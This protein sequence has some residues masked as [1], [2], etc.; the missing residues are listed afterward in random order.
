[1]LKEE[2]NC[3]V[4]KS[5]ILSKIDFVNH[6]FSTR[7]G[8]VSKNE[9]SS[10]NLGYNRGDLTENV[11]QNFSVLLKSHGFKGGIVSGKQIHGKEIYLAQKKDREKYFQGYD[12]FI[13]KEKGVLL[14][15]FHADCIPVFFVDEKIKAIGLAHSGW[16]GTF[17]NIS[18]EI[19][20]SMEEEFNSKKE[21]IK[22]AIG[23]SICQNCFEVDEDVY[24][25]FNKRYNFLDKYYF[26]KGEKFHI[27]LKSIIEESLINYGLNPTNIEK[28]HLCTMCNEDLF[29]SHRRNGNKRGS[30]AAFMELR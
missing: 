25:L 29:Y 20:K 5:E 26:T 3:V 21:D 2:N 28:T 24:F 18:L 10:L 13:T 17:E 14:T 12:G 15:T 1:M 4:Y 9:F 7:Q 30:M 6:C 16:K 11:D 27:D 8:G 19:I 23:P 22:V